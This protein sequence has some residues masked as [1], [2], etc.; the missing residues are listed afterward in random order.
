MTNEWMA[1]D[2]WRMANAAT[3]RAVHTNEWM[4]DDKWRMA[5]GKCRYEKGRPQ[6]LGARTWMALPRQLSRQRLHH[7]VAL[8]ASPVQ[9]QRTIRCRLGFR[10][11]LNRRKDLCGN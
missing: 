2:K 9:N 4:A 3:K 1:D 5:D 10:C 7:G 11:K 8:M 6:F